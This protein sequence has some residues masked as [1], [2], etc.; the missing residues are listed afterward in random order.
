M[1]PMPL[2]QSQSKRDKLNGKGWCRMVEI[3]RKGRF[4]VRRDF[5]GP[6]I[7]QHN[8]EREA[9][10]AAINSGFDRAYVD[11]PEGMTVTFIIPST[12]PPTAPPA[13]VSFWEW[14]VATDGLAG[15]GTDSSPLV[16]LAEI[17]FSTLDVGSPPTVLTVTA[18]GD[19]DFGGVS[20][21]DVGFEN[22]VTYEIVFEL[23]GTNPNIVVYTGGGTPKQ[24]GGAGSRSA[25]VT[26]DG[27]SLVFRWDGNVIDGDT[28]TIGARVTA[29]VT[30]PV[31]VPAS[32]LGTIPATLNLTVGQTFVLNN[33]SQFVVGDA[34]ITILIGTDNSGNA[35]FAN[36]TLTITGHDLAD[37]TVTVSI[38]ADNGL[39]SPIAEHTF[40]LSVTAAPVIS[41]GADRFARYAIGG[42]SLI[43]TEPTR[44][45][46]ALKTKMVIF[47]S[48]PDVESGFGVTY[49][50]IMDTY[51]ALSP[52]TKRIL[53]LDIAE[54]FPPTNSTWLDIYNYLDTNNWWA[55]DAGDAG[56]IIFND[57]FGQNVTHLSPVG[58]G[59]DGNGDNMQQW[60]TS[61][62][63]SAG[64]PNE[65][66]WV[67]DPLKWDGV[68]FDIAGSEPDFSF[69]M[70]RDG[71]SDSRNAQQSRVWH[72][73]AMVQAFQR[74]RDIYAAAGAPEPIILGNLA[75]WA[76]EWEKDAKPAG[77]Y[78][79]EWADEIHGGLVME[80]EPG[81]IYAAYGFL[82]WY[83]FMGN[84]GNLRDWDGNA[85][86]NPQ[87]GDQIR[88]TWGSTYQHVD[89]M[90]FYDPANGY[91]QF[92][93]PTY[94]IQE[95]YGP[96]PDAA[97]PGV[98]AWHRVGFTLN[99]VYS[100]H[101]YDYGALGL[102]GTNTSFGDYGQFSE[103]ERSRGG[104]TPQGPPA[105]APPPPP[106]LPGIGQRFFEDE[107][108]IQHLLICNGH[109]NAN[110]PAYALPA[111]TW[112]DPDGT[113]HSGT[114][115]INKGD[116][117]VLRKLG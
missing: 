58:V 104:L 3:T 97:W 26:S 8:V 69:D 45:D 19:N 28:F 36:D 40:T 21:G 85:L 110:D 13:P 27:G 92:K 82:Y 11:Y 51:E 55:R 1:P 115:S 108:L 25:I 50:S 117:K 49:S 72:R 73:Q 30:V 90:R 62:Y 113:D 86:P 60:H 20:F 37:D 70:D 99:R 29:N 79:P 63:L 56:E 12:K 87:E 77:L 102:A 44:S 22:G 18:G 57:G 107:S 42:N 5:G 66:G 7:S 81:Q 98:E 106:A 105:S 32:F 111:G 59:V 61:A 88:N 96:A 2:R 93:S 80:A 43:N 33:V 52:D 94:L 109:D 35:V 9:I 47:H 46:F 114:I 14:L 39:A 64:V 54:T 38:T 78:V 100:N 15:N 65:F 74:V 31:G 53:Y 10:E 34:P 76:F 71:A 16:P 116:G 17:N 103:Y 4:V 23:G 48:H 24:V 112:R 83:P 67:F 84:P 6:I 95:A 75:R 101:Y 41:G 89:R 68:F 91:C